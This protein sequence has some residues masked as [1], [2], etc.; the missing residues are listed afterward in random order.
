M[1]K[2]LYIIITSTVLIF[3]FNQCHE[4]ECDGNKLGDLKFTQTDLNILPYSIIDTIIFRDSIGDSICYYPNGI[5]HSTTRLVGDECSDYYNTELNITRFKG[6]DEQTYMHLYL[7]FT[8]PFA[9]EKK[10]TIQIIV[11]YKD[12]IEWSFNA[13]YVFDSLKLYDYSTE[14]Y[15]ILGYCDSLYVGPN[16]FHSVYTLEQT[17]IPSEHRNLKT[18]FYSL[19]EGIVGFKTDDG[20]LWYLKKT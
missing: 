19:I 4:K 15:A 20:H 11:H 7:D 2:S 8:W 9:T 18:L 3:L 10:K 17:Y 16:M 12:S 13:I 5:R 1:K 6:I 14:S